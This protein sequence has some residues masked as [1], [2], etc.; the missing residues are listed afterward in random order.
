MVRHL[1]P[2]AP[3]CR[4]KRLQNSDGPEAAAKQRAAKLAA[5]YAALAADTVE[6]DPEEAAPVVA[7]P[8]PVAPT[9]AARE[10]PL[11]GPALAAEIQ[12]LF[13]AIE[14]TEGLAVLTTTGAKDRYEVQR[15]CVLQLR[16]V[17][18]RLHAAVLV[19]KDG[20]AQRSAA[21]QQ[22]GAGQLH[23]APEAW[24]GNALRRERAS[25]EK[26]PKRKRGWQLDP[27]SGAVA[28][29]SAL[30]EEAEAAPLLKVNKEPVHRRQTMMQK[31]RAAAAAAEAADFGAGSSGALPHG[32]KPRRAAQQPRRAAQQPRRA[33]QQPRSATD[34]VKGAPKSAA[35]ASS[36][37]VQQ[38]DFAMINARLVTG[39]AAMARLAKEPMPV[40]GELLEA[41][42]RAAAAHLERGGGTAASAVLDTTICVGAA[43]M[44]AV[45]ICS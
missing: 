14:S 44:A 10:A 15:E 25:C 29:S 8:V 33:A 4:Y 36:Q 12:R 32:E 5:K 16:S 17:E 2:A 9:R 30:E 37:S 38:P 13:A 11:A 18:Q 1:D 20:A 35:A 26:G 24:A 39:S 34:M 27:T 43:S 7:L 21:Q 19:A 6:G 42:R 3:T 22:P 41:M 31:A 23:V 28:G 45:A 40:A